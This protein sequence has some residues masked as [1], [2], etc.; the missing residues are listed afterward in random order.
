MLLAT[1]PFI[2]WLLCWFHPTSPST[3]CM[4]PPQQTELTQCLMVHWVLMT[5]TLIVPLISHWRYQILLLMS[6]TAVDVFVMTHV[7][8]SSG[9]VPLT[10]PVA[11]KLELCPKCPRHPS[12]PQDHLAIN[13]LHQHVT[14][15]DC[16]TFW[17]SPYGITQM[18]S[19]L[20]HFPPDIVIC[21]HLVMVC[22]ILPGTLKNYAAGL[23]HFTKFC[24]NFNIP[25][26]EHACF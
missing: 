25:E 1:L 8:C 7:L 21:R 20:S 23:S 16:F 17:L 22:C 10:V 4:W 15:S 9:S 14:A 18:N 3:P 6:D 2:E 26:V 24:D 19:E 12:N 13:P 11:L 5:F